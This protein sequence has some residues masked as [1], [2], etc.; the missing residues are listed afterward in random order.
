MSVLSLTFGFAVSSDVEMAT[1]SSDAMEVTAEKAP[2]EPTE[3]ITEEHVND[4]C[5]AAIRAKLM[6]NEVALCALQA[7][8]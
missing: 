5:A 2:A 6:G 4:L 8:F 7:R 3:P 1:A